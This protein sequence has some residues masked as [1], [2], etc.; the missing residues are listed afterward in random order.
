PCCIKVLNPP[1]TIIIL[2]LIVSISVNAQKK[3]RTFKN[4]GE[5]EDY[6]AE[7]QFEENYYEESYRKF[8]ET[9][10]IIDEN[11]IKYNN[12]VLI[13]DVE[14]KLKPIFE[15]GIF[16]PEIITGKVKSGQAR[17]EELDSMLIRNDSMYISNLKEIKSPHP[18][19]IKRFRF[20]LSQKGS[21]NP[22]ACLIEL[23]NNTATKNTKLED[24][25]IGSR[26]TFFKSGWKAI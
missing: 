17:K 18:V 24:F 11:T 6:W 23:T 20:W 14:K 25:I 26:I 5:Q 4:Q 21:A 2:F 8:K 22:T 15:K 16:Y 3:E 7:K 10:V 1:V 19:T 12:E 13:L 9:I